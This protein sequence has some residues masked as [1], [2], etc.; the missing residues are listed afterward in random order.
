MTFLT[1][2]EEADG[3]GPADVV[4][5]EPEAVEAPATTADEG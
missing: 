2:E 4:E 1:G 5:A 3:A